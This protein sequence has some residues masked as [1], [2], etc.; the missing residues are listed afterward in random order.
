MVR[1]DV[2]RHSKRSVWGAILALSSAWWAGDVVAQD[3]ARVADLQLIR[4][5]HHIERFML[6]RN[7]L[8][9]LERCVIGEQAEAQ[10]GLAATAVCIA[11]ASMVERVF[12]L[13][14]GAHRG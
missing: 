9:A 11:K 8:P 5:E 3:S 13:F 7:L 14:G 2:M 12:P 1:E 4:N 10:S 6:Q